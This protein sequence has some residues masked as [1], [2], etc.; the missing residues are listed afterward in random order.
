MLQQSD[1]NREPSLLVVALSLAAGLGCVAI[2]L[3]WPYLIWFVMER[4]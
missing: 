3:F 2:C 4:G 1:P